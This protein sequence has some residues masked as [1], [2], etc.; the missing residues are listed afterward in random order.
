MIKAFSTYM[1]EIIN[2]HKIL[3]GIAQRKRFFERL[4]INEKI[5][6]KL[7]LERETVYEGMDWFQQAQ[8]KEIF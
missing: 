7:V 2:V 5:M 3:L 8:D 1:E 6:L 4:G